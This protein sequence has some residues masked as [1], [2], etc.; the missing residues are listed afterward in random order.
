MRDGKEPSG[1]LFFALQCT[2]TGGVAS[3]ITIA[4]TLLNSVDDTHKLTVLHYSIALLSGY[5]TLSLPLFLIG[6][7][8]R[9]TEND[10]LPPVATLLVGVAYGT[11][12]TYLLTADVG[13]WAS[14]LYGMIFWLPL[15]GI[16][17]LSL[18]IHSKK[19]I[20]LLSLILPLSLFLAAL[21]MRHL[22]QN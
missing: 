13:F 6:L 9:G 8:H 19:T 14:L 15:E 11:L 21:L 12:F 17:R 3:T 16:R 22:F 20:R 7:L 2:S 4:L 10:L 5:A 1:A 18:A